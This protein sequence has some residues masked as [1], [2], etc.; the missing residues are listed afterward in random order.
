MKRLSLSR[1]K[2]AHPKEDRQQQKISSF[3]GSGAN[4]FKTPETVVKRRDENREAADK[5]FIEGTPEGSSVDD[6]TKKK[7]RLFK[8]KK[9]SSKLGLLVAS[10]TSLIAGNL[11]K[12]AT[13]IHSPP[14]DVEKSVK[15]RGLSPGDDV[16]NATPK[17]Q[18]F[19]PPSKAHISTP[20][21]STINDSNS[22]SK[23][24]TK[25]KSPVKIPTPPTQNIIDDDDEE[26]GSL[27]SESKTVSR[28]ATEENIGGNA[29]CASFGRHV[30]KSVESS[31]KNFGCQELSM[32]IED[33]I[34]EGIERKCVLR[35][36]WADTKVKIGDVVNILCVD[37]DVEEIVINDLNGLVVVNPDMLVSGTSIVSTLFCMR[38]AVLNERFKGQ[39][40]GS[41][42]MLIGTLV[43]ELLQ[44]SLRQD[45][46]T[47]EAISA[48][49]EKCLCQGPILKSLLALNMNQMEM[50]K[51]VE[52][53]L[54]HIKYFT[55]KYVLGKNS[56]PPDPAFDIGGSRRPVKA[57]VWPGKVEAIKD[58]EENIWSPRLGI[59]GKVDLTVQVRKIGE[60]SDKILPLELKTGRPSGS[61]EHRGQV[62]L[63][64][65]M[66]SE[67]RPD[68][69]S[70]LLLYLRTSSMQEVK[71]GIHEMRGLVQLRN[72]LA[73]H[74]GDDF[75]VISIAL[76]RKKNTFT[77]SITIVFSYFRSF[78]QDL[79]PPINAK[80]AC[81]ECAHLTSCAVY[82]KLK[83]A[84]P[85]APHSMS[86][87]VPVVLQHLEREDLEFFN[88]WIH[89]NSLESGEARRGSRLKNLWCTT[90]QSR[91]LQGQAVC[92]LQVQIQDAHDA[93]SGSCVTFTKVLAA[94]SSIFQVGDFVIV[95]SMRGELA[96]GQGSITSITS[97]TIVL[98]MDKVKL[99]PDTTYVLDKYEY[100]SH[101]G[102]WL[103]LSKLMSDTEDSRRIRNILLGRTK[104]SFIG[105]LPKEV[106][107]IGK[108]ILRPL[109]RVQQK[110]IFKTLMT[111]NYVLLKG[112]PG[113]GKTTMIVAMVRLLVKMNKTV[114]LT[115]YT[116]SALDHLL[117]KLLEH[118]P[119]FLRLGRSTRVHPSLREHTEDTLIEQ[120]QIDTCQAL[121]KL[122]NSQPVIGVTCLTALQHPGLLKRKF[123]F[124]IQDE[125][126]QSLLLAALG[127]LFLADKFVLVGDPQ[128]LP[129]VV[130]N[131]QAKKLGLDQSLFSL[132]ED[133][134]NTIPLSVQYRM[135]QEI[136][137]LANHMTYQGQLECGNDE[138]AN[139]HIDIKDSSRFFHEKGSSSSVLFL[140]TSDMT[141]MSNMLEARDELGISNHGEAELVRK[142]LIECLPNNSQAGVGIIAPFRAQVSLLRKKISHFSLTDISTVDQFQG[143]D[144][145]VIVISCTRT[146][147]KKQINS[148]ENHDDD[149][150]SDWRRLNVA[151]T[152]AKA[153]LWMIGNARALKT[154]PPFGKMLDYLSH[155]DLIV[156]L[157]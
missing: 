128:Q 106:A 67:R 55:E 63:Y 33:S 101:S 129:P 134:H 114:L 107:L 153:K 83:D 20:T 56:S 111:E 50:R 49:L 145:D 27:I 12:K 48:Q 138:V 28:K 4:V 102:P 99:D 81:K 5:D 59:K 88:R 9:R 79:P 37:K 92:D 21:K 6:N 117:L 109:N 10:T 60:K 146:K 110:A 23:S 142:I 66:M 70:G 119:C 77:F 126:G 1:N 150:L 19:E 98:N 137:D 115:S 136:Q 8:L 75:E 16:E 155:R 69:E 152:R 124:C 82:Q 105:G 64:S 34:S 147:P 123:D 68:P 85:S 65:M 43:H 46:R 57:Q 51:E 18:K 151:V 113:S 148:Q 36:S 47:T 130:K 80:R 103:T 127:P 61:A 78:P 26:Q 116:H 84:I 39:D 121:D 44:E 154:Y 31:A 132:L 149:I 120:N 91:E 32:T 25:L 17:Q 96:L 41:R 131:I 54:P 144:K 156:K 24:F 30:V 71:A 94:S 118:E 52:P 133:Q 93:S 22:S 139:K 108:S 141:S 15:K 112:M 122:Y 42:T 87:L 40:T 73:S 89:M 90:P 95:S 3:F 14:Q 35:G 157:Q 58:I 125:A 100:S 13:K 140:D 2:K 135:N 86:E 29:I 38:K 97:D 74:I 143:R 7:R 11:D 45:L 76:K 72:S 53:F 62:I 104:A